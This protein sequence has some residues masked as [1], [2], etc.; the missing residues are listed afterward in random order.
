NGVSI[1]LDEHVNVTTLG[2]FAAGLIQPQDP[3]ATAAVMAAGPQPGQ[4]VMDFCAAPGTKTTHLAQLMAG[5]GSILA[6]DVSNEKLDRV[7]Q[8]AG[9]LGIGIVQTR[10]AS[11]IGSLAPESFDLVLADVPCSNTGVLARR[12]EARWRFT[13]Q[14]L[15][16]IVTDQQFL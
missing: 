1:V 12:P 13:P 11:D 2:P 6:V 14:R 4:S 10:L 9:R 8:S 15:E 5:R 16:K 3:T 7:R